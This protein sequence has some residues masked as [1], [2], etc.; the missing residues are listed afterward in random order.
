MIVKPMTRHRLDSCYIS[1]IRLLWLTRL[2]TRRG[3]SLHAKLMRHKRQVAQRQILALRAFYIG[4]GNTQ[5]SDSTSDTSIA[6][7]TVANNK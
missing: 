7:F 5:V 6:K 3:N 4:A 1:L 2:G